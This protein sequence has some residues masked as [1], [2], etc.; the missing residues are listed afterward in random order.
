MMAA[1]KKTAKADKPMTK[2][3]FIKTFAPDVSADEIVAKGKAAGLELT[4]KFIW[5]LQSEMRKASGTTR[6]VGKAAKGKKAVK[7]ATSKRAAV[8]TA[9]PVAAAAALP[10]KKGTSKKGAHTARKNGAA[11]PAKAAAGS[12]AEQKLKALVIE[13]GTAR[14]DELYRS[15]RDQLNAILAR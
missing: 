10:K 1:K 2:T 15:V 14:A 3:G 9:A 6:K 7:V 11:T 4:K 12:S 8:V 13:L 5:T